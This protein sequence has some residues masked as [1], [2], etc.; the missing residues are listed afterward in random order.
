MLALNHHRVCEDVEK[1][2]KELSVLKKEK[3]YFLN[4]VKD[5]SDKRSVLIDELQVSSLVNT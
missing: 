5:D 3:E 1:L 2:Q 4:Q